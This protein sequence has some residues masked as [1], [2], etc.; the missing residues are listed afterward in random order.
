MYKEEVNKTL[1]VIVLNG[2]R[3][4][5][6]VEGGAVANDLLRH[7]NLLDGG[8]GGVNLLVAFNVERKSGA[9]E[10]IRCIK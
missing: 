4:L 5:V 10:A 3:D 7:W 6:L 9:R 8:G 2:T 1:A